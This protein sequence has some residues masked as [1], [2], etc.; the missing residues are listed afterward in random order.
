MERELGPT[1][2]A[3]TM[4][5][6]SARD[7]TGDADFEA[8]VAQRLAHLLRLGRALTGDEQQG[9]DLVQDALERTLLAWS[10]VV[11]P[12]AF[13]RRVMVNRS[14]SVWR[15]LRREEPLSDEHDRAGIDRP[16]DHELLAAVR[17]LPARQRAVIALRYYEDLTEVQTAEV[18]GC[19][20]G[21]VKSQ[22]SRAMAFLRAALP[23]FAD[24]EELS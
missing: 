17:R 14:V 7:R 15:K 6:M 16:R 13:V 21:T 3:A 19:S 10:K 22:A 20:V 8:F 4:R 24:R 11:D 9:A 23:T 18:M 1:V 5:S 2:V 12:D